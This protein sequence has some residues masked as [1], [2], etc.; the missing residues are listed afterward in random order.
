MRRAIAITFFTAL[1]ALVAAPSTLGQSSDPLA[2]EQWNMSMVEAPAA[3]G[4]ATGKGAIVAVI[5]TGVDRAHE[6]LQGRLLPARDFVDKDDTPNDENGH[7][8]H[9]L[10]IVAANSGNGRGVTSVAPGAKVLPIRVLD[11]DGGGFGED[12]A[13]GIDFA[14]S[15]GADVINLS[16]S[17]TVPFGSAISGDDSVTRALDRALDAGVVVAAA[18]GN[19]GLPVCENPSA[20]GRLLC[21]GA[22]DRRGERSFFSSFGDGLGLVAPG[23]SGL[24]IQGEDVLS[25]YFD[26]AEPGN[27]SQYIEIA[28]TSQATPHVAGV[29]ALLVSRGVTGQAAVRR[30]LATAT[31]AGADGPDGQYGAGI[32]NARRAVSGLGGGAGGG[33]GGGSASRITLKK[34]HSVRKVLRRGIRFRCRGAGSGRCSGRATVKGRK[35]AAGSKRLTA[36]RTITVTARLTKGGRKRLR[37]IRSKRGT[38]RLKVRVR[39]RVPGA[40]SQTRKIAIRG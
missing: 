8:T 9:V 1:A 21:V 26:P 11:A 38:Q 36:S 33:T 28:G 14:V 12:V 16:L 25:T 34:L 5:D 3:H 18:S 37:R 23:G 39:I 7:G 35:I 19:N 17:D 2:G 15:R 27:H 24:P 30:I 6:D 29:A 40:S 4:T 13:S 32:V 10:G 22:V 20:E 31:D